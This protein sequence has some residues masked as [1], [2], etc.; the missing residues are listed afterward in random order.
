MVVSNQPQIHEWYQK[1]KTHALMIGRNCA[2]T[3]SVEDLW[4]K[5]PE[6]QKISWMVTFHRYSESEAIGSVSFRTPSLEKAKRLA[7][8]TYKVLFPNRCTRCECIIDENTD[9]NICSPDCNYFAH[10]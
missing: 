9:H 10:F 4:Y 7:I 5:D 3:M 6:V 2:I 8:E 1:E